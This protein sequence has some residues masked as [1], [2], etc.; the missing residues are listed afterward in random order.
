MITY[1]MSA[2]SLAD[3]IEKSVEEA[4]EIIASFYA[5]FKGVKKLTDDSQKMLKETG[6]VTDM[7]G[8]R[9]HIPD[10]QLPDY[11]VV[12]LKK[13]SSFNPLIGAVE[14]DDKVIQ[15][16]IRDFQA[17]LKACKWKKDRD[18]VV[19]QA[20]KE[21]FKVTN[22][23]GFISRALRQCLNA[24]IQGTAS[25]MTKYAMVMINNDAEL[26]KLG[27]KL[28]ATIHDEV[29]GQAPREN[30]EAAAKRLSEVM[31]AAASS[32]CQCPFKCDPYMTSAWYEDEVCSA[33]KDDYAKFLKD[34]SEDDAML[35][36]IRKYSMFTAEG[37]RKVIRDDYQINTDDI[38]ILKGTTC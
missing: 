17:K 21:G 11:S 1:G 15:A 10:A 36:T 23:Q 4:E 25:S 26:N 35:K 37:I 6:Y 28:L 33:I 7:W 29:F 19:T 9:R 30:A 22:N 27:F 32:K 24:R 12:P 3:R 8:R 18:K 13:Q 34:S 2:R 5:G 14:R 16:K 31:V 20:E 38:K